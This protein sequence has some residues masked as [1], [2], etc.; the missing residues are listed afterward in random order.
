MIITGKPYDAT[1]ND[2]KE[3][4]IRKKR[5]VYSTVGNPT[6]YQKKLIDKMEKGC[7]EGEWKGD[8][9][10]TMRNA[11]YAGIEF[12]EEE[13]RADGRWHRM[14]DPDVPI[15]LMQAGAL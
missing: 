2:A 10:N 4:N 5:V 3:R 9:Y 15:T 8:P 6:A 13:I 11:E 7:V 1:D 12:W 14:S